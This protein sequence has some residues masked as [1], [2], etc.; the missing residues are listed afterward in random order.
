MAPSPGNVLIV[1]DDDGIR[2]LLA[3]VA[4]RDGF[5]IRVAGDG[6]GALKALGDGGA[7]P[8][9]ILLDLIMPNVD[10]FGVLSHLDQNAPH[11][12]Q[13]VIVLTAAAESHYRNR[14]EMERV[15]CIRRKPLEIDDL[16]EQILRCA[17]AGRA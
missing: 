12:L 8:D 17:A 13:R 2:S 10:G 14:P 9:V 11:L 16:S 7:E 1:E 6:A 3:A 4:E 5:R 15:W